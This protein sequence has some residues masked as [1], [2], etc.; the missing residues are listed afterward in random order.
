MKRYADLLAEAAARV[1]EIMPWTLRDQLAAGHDILLI[2]VREP[3]EFAQLHIAGS[4]NVPRG[5]LEQACEWD[6]DDTVPALAAARD[7]TIV[8]I[9]R[10]GHR[11]VFAA[12]VMQQLGYTRVS[13]L[14]TGVRGWNDNEQP[15]QNA[16]GDAVDVDDGDVLLAA[17]VKPEQ[18]KPT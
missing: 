5:V 10:S 2:D 13:S 16:A 3:A 12:D 1:T 9:C 14:R 7:Q 6:F 8:V 4:I 15:L 18:R 17:K 11:S